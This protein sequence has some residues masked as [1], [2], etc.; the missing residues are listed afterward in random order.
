MLD[1]VFSGDLW[2]ILMFCGYG[3]SH[4]WQVQDVNKCVTFDSSVVAHI[5]L[6]LIDINKHIIIS[7]FYDICVFVNI[8]YTLE[9]LFVED[10][11]EWIYTYS[12]N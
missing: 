4:V 3:R 6:L 9:Y 2:R 8:C 7:I 1:M 12:P 10:E 11:S 5:L